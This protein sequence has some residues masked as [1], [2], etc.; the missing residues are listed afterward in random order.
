MISFIFDFSPKEQPVLESSEEK[1][2]LESPE[3]QLVLESP[4]KQPTLESPEQPVLESPEK[5]STLERPEE[6][7]TLESPEQRA[8]E[9]PGD[10][11]SVLK[12]PEEQHVLES[13]GDEQSERNSAQNLDFLL[14]CVQDD[15]PISTEMDFDNEKRALCA[16]SIVSQCKLV[17]LPEENTSIENGREKWRKGLLEIQP[18]IIILVHFVNIRL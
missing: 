16:Q 4:E 5:Q 17:R 6:Q 12:S 10:D 3:E 18:V 8:L 11:Q 7:P 2:T 9:S 14:P 13:P 1:S 15:I